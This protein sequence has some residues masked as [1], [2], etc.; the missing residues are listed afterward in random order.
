MFSPDLD[1]MEKVDLTQLRGLVELTRKTGVGDT[2][3][4]QIVSLES[5]MK[6]YARGIEW[7]LQAFASMQAVCL[8]LPA[9]AVIDFLMRAASTLEIRNGEQCAL[10]K[11]SASWNL[12]LPQHCFVP[13]YLADT[14]KTGQQAKS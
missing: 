11:F 9:R 10:H 14:F 2:F 8:F 6:S 5:Q 3:F 1:H 4:F 13:S 12:S 7:S